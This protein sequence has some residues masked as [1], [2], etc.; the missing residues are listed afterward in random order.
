MF[1]QAATGIAS[2]ACAAMLNEGLSQKQ[3]QDRIFMFDIDG[4]LTTTRAK[5]VPDHAK[6]FAKDVEPETD[7]EK[8]VAK[9]KPSCLIGKV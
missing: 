8:A 6:A 4:L 5:G 2:L 3:A 1:L 9:I 7:F